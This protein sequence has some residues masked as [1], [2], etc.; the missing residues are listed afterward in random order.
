MAIATSAASEVASAAHLARPLTV[1]DQVD[2]PER[3]QTE[4]GIASTWPTAAKNG[5]EF[6][7]AVWIPMARFDPPTARV[8]RQTAG[9]PVNCPC[10]SAMNEA[11]PS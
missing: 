10:A 7:R 6:W 5:V 3:L 2:P 9:R 11:A 8:P 1:A 4:Q